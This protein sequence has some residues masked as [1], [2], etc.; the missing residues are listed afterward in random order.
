MIAAK[1][2]D[3]EEVS[4]RIEELSKQRAAALEGKR[5][6]A[7]KAGAAGGFDDAAKKAL[8][9]SVKDNPLAGLSL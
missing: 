7:A 8:R 4:K 1:R 3:R 5:A 9:K 2:K 6:E